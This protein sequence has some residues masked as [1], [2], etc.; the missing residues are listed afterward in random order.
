MAMRAIAVGDESSPQSAPNLQYAQWTSSIYQLEQQAAVEAG[1]TLGSVKASADYRLLVIDVA[2]SA[3]RK[4]PRTR[5]SETWG[6]GYRLLVEISDV[7]NVTSLTL[8]AI[9]ASVELGQVKASVRL[10]VNGYT[11]SELWNELPVPR[12]LDVDTYKD[13]IAAAKRIQKAFFEH[14]DKA[15]PVKLADNDESTIAEGGVNE[16]EIRESVVLVGLM[17]RIEDRVPQ[18]SAAAS[19]TLESDLP[20]EVV[21]QLAAGLYATLRVGTDDASRRAGAE[22]AAAFLNPLR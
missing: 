15:L 1:F 22:R 2:R 18:G 17:K 19:L 21:D 16:T 5:R 4:I 14:P 13:Y 9:A 6:Y 8:P 20:A 10:E 12:P 3:V 7:S 11:G